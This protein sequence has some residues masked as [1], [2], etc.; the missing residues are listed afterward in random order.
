MFVSIVAVSLFVFAIIKKAVFKKSIALSATKSLT[1]SNVIIIC[2]SYYTG[3]T[4][5]SNALWAVPIILSTILLSYISLRNNIKK[6][7]DL[8]CN[9]IS[10]LSNVKIIHSEKELYKKDDE[11][12]N[13]FKALKAYNQRMHEIIDRITVVSENI[14]RSGLSLTDN[15]TQLANLSN[16]NV[17]LSTE[18]TESIDEMAELLNQSNS[19]AVAARSIVNESSSNLK[20]FSS[21]S[22]E[23]L[24]S[25]ETIAKRITIINEIAFQTNILALNAAVEAARAGEHGRGFAVVAAEV[26]KLTER[27]KMA[28]D[29]IEQLSRSMVTNTSRTNHL[30]THLIPGMNKNSEL[31]EEIFDSSEKQQESTNQINNSM[32]QLSNSTQASLSIADT[33]AS[34][35]QDLTEQ[36][37][38]LRNVLSFF[39]QS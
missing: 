39:M 25:I 32:Q 27:S 6:P 36:T 26:R 37:N 14:H 4:N 11:I 10:D 31:V 20:T 35:S 30:I 23:N 15:S 2:V 12:G 34:S 18:V 9:Q 13:V 7:L 3:S 21:A 17:T 16:Q 5:L 22:E 38:E 19:N 8:V 28:A 24:S 33:Q 1:I 29:E